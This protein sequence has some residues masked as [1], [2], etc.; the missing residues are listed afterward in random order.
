MTKGVLKK[1]DKEFLGL[2]E[3]GVIGCLTLFGSFIIE[4]PIDGVAYLGILLVVSILSYTKEWKTYLYS[5]IISMIFGVIVLTAEY[6][7][8]L[9][10][11]VYILV[12]GLALISFA[13]YDEKRKQTEKEQGEKQIPIEQVLDENKIETPVA[14]SQVITTQVVETPV[15]EPTPVVEPQP[16][17][18]ETKVVE[19][20]PSIKLQIV[21]DT[22]IE[23]SIKIEEQ[24]IKQTGAKKSNKATSVN[25]HKNKR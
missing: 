16:V 9:P 13:M 23:N 24:K 19:Q 22:S 20:K 10:W 15:E 21:E 7:K 12:I 25:K 17:V 11:Y 8:E 1:L 5:S 2:I 6:W 4:E 3:C 18:E 14:E